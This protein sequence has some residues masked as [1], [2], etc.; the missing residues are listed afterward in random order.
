M[1]EN[2]S[3]STFYFSNKEI[4]LLGAFLILILACNLSLYWDILVAI[5]FM[6]LFLELF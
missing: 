5:F 3:K 1:E 4:A 6:G 2:K